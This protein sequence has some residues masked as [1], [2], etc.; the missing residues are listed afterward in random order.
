MT[1]SFT[2]KLWRDFSR[3]ERGAVTVDWVVLSAA[4]TL[5]GMAAFLG[6]QSGSNQL[7]GEIDTALDGV[8]LRT[9]NQHAGSDDPDDAE[10]DAAVPNGGSSGGGSSGGGLPGDGSTAGGQ[11][12]GGSASG[13][14]G[15]DGSTDANAGGDG[16][17]AQSSGDGSTEADC[18]AL[19]P[20][21]GDLGDAPVIDALI[22]SNMSGL[23]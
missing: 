10:N 9:L 2:R 7:A 13:G 5:L 15:D 1:W 20:E 6:V 4:I 17:D 12:G 23:T 11:S 21:C 19:T 8:E 14:V 3:A 22:P 18:H 16:G